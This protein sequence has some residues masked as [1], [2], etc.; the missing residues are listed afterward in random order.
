MVNHLFYHMPNNSYFTSDLRGFLKKDSL[1]QW[2]EANDIA[3]QNIR[4]HVSK[5]ICDRYFDTT[6]DVVL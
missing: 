5:N 3:F 2:S 1:F 4:N 6:K